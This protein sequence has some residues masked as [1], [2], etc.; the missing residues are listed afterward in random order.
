MAD[1]SM[2]NLPDPQAIQAR[3]QQ[4]LRA[5]WGSGNAAAMQQATVTNA[6]DAIF[7]NPEVNRAK[8]VQKVLG[9]ATNQ[10]KPVEGETGI[11][12]ELRRLQAMRDAVGEIDPTIANQ[13]NT[14]ILQLGQIKVEQ[15]KLFADQRRDDRKE[16]R[17]I[18]EYSANMKKSA[19]DFKQKEAEG[20]NYWRKGPNGLE[21]MNV[22]L[23]DAVVRNQLRAGGWTEGNGPNTEAEA[24][25]ALSKKTTSD[26]EAQLGKAD[27]GLAAIASTVSQWDPSFNQ[28]P[29]QLLMK[30]NNLA[31][32]MTG[33]SLSPEI[34]QRAGKYEQWRANTTDSV[35]RYINLI[36]GSAMG[37]E[38]AK[39]IMST[40]P[41]AEDGSTAY[42]AKTR[43]AVQRLL[44]IRKRSAT[45]LSS[46]LN[47]SV[48]DIEKMPLPTVTQQ[49]VEQFGAAF[50]LPPM[51]VTQQPERGVSPSSLDSRI[52][53]ILNGK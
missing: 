26:L 22:P 32:Y 13:V 17:D 15:D 16:V 25:D 35:N 7:G 2:F 38:E 29:T 6:L 44:Q 18:G 12:T 31:E 4:Q 48:K 46:G 37:V 36:T 27:E 45:A 11:E 39:R 41:N 34:A 3:N 33:N 5:Q 8:A 20:Q 50:G 24:S 52:N 23:N 14:R 28:L 42:V 53:S 10:L 19:Q 51:G 49:E 43:S 47:L 9:E 21:R 40:M 1:L 30:G